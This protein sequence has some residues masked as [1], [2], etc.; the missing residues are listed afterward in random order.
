MGNSSTVGAQESER[1]RWLQVI[2]RKKMHKGENGDEVR[3][4]GG[5]EGGAGEEYVEVA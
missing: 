1:P 2:L 3:G 5:G 4:W